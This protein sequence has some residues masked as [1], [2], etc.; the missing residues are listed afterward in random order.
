VKDFWIKLAVGALIIGATFAFAWK[1]GHLVRL[2]VYVKETRDELKKCAWP[3]RDELKETTVLI[4]IVFAGM[5][6]FTV[7]ADGLF[8]NVVK[9]LLK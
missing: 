6:L 3:S 1:Q 7:A 4:L 5:G 9:L 2:S 8:I